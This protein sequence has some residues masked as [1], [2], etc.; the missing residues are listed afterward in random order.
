MRM[1]LDANPLLDEHNTPISQTQD[2][3]IRMCNGFGKGMA[4]LAD[5]YALAK[6]GN[7]ALILSVREDMNSYYDSHNSIICGERIFCE[8]D[9]LDDRVVRYFGSTVIKPVEMSFLIFEE[10]GG[11]PT[12]GSVLCSKGGLDLF[13]FLFKTHDN[14]RTID[15]YY[16][17]LSGESSDET[18]V[19]SASHLGRK[20]YPSRSICLYNNED[21]AYIFLGANLSDCG[22]SRAMRL[23]QR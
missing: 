20:E 14:A 5:Y 4:S 21:F 18:R 16:S 17:L 15:E 12:L 9:S 19:M 22:R 10:Y 6:S 8:P 7:K 13:Q 23:E 2:A 11:G 1:I 3:H